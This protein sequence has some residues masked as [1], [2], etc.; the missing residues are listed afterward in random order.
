M[1]IRLKPVNEQV[2]VITGASSGIGRATARL[3]GERGAAVVLAARQEEALRETVD[4]IRRGGGRATYIT[5]DVSEMHEVEGIV[6][7]AIAE[8]GRIDTWVNNAAVSIYGRLDETPLEDARRLFDINF[9]GMVHGSMAAKR[10]LSQ[11]GGALIN[12]GSMT[13]E[14]AMPLLGFYSASKQAVKGFTDALRMEIEKDGAAVAV[15]LIK[16]GSIDT[17]F[18]EHARNHMDREPALPPPVYE[19]AVVARA[20]L[21]CAEHPQRDVLVGG[22]ARMFTAWE[23]VAP[24]VLDRYMEA[25]MFEQQKKDH[26][27]SSTEGDNMYAPG[28]IS[29]YRERG[30]HEGHVMKSSAYTQA[31]L[32]PVATITAA[33]L[34]LVAVGSGIGR[35]LRH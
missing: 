29:R 22:G 13:S 2:I 12:I 32:H 11:H 24:R 33:A 23:A 27:P 35:L 15:T 31:S 8:F 10:E 5:A 28:H 25:S 4:E 18:T 1:D 19:P 14:R 21:H 26:A 16:P 9:W 20:V 34:A 17:P 30:R 7:H 6:R 3:A